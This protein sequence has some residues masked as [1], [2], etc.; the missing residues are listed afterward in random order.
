MAEN[1]P[2][3]V[4][5]A[6]LQI[7]AE[8]TPNKINP[9]KYMPGHIIIKLLK[10]KDK[11]YWE[12]NNYWEQ[13]EWNDTLSIGF[14]RQLPIQVRVIFSYETVEAREELHIFSTAEKK[15]INCQLYTHWNYPSGMHRK[16]TFSDDGKL[17]EFFACRPTLKYWL[18]EVLQQKGNVNNMQEQMGNFSW[19][20]G[21]LRKNEKEMLEMKHNVIEMKN[22]F[23]QLIN[24]LDTAKERISDLKKHR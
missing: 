12:K 9:K 18:N 8:Q 5:S 17:K 15:P 11:K 2:N 24:R 10:T 7:S 3:L 6:N 21:T 19:A 22:A 13:P 20:M 14:Y 4:K 16:K 23:D 1:F